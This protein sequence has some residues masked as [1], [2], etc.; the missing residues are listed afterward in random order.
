QLG[1]SSDSQ[2]HFY[3]EN[4]NEQVSISD[5]NHTPSGFGY[6]FGCIE[7]LQKVGYTVPSLSVYVNSS[8]PMGSG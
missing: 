7:V 5:I 6:I 1:F 8:V 3:S 4:L 2:H